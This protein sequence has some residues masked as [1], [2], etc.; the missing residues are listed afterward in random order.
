MKKNLPISF[1]I[2]SLFFTGCSINFSSVQSM[3]EDHSLAGRTFSYETL[4]LNIKRNSFDPG[5]KKINTNIY[6]SN[7][8][9]DLFSK[10]YLISQDGRSNLGLT[11]KSKS[12]RHK[13]TG[14]D[15]IFIFTLGLF[16]T[17]ESSESIV[18]FEL[19]DRKNQKVIRTW[20]YDASNTAISSWLT[21][22]FSLLLSPFSNSVSTAAIGED[23]AE[24]QPL[25]LL[26]EKFLQDFEYSLHDEKFRREVQ[27]LATID[28]STYY[29]AYPVDPAGNLPQRL[30][31]LLGNTLQDFF[32]KNKFPTEAAAT[33]EYNLDQE[34]DLDIID[35]FKEYDRQDLIIIPFLKEHTGNIYTGHLVMVDSRNKEVVFDQDFKIFATNAEQLAYRLYSTF[36]QILFAKDVV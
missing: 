13:Y 33:I 29:I 34:N 17:V 15:L 10:T 9:F 22:P 1:I 4:P 28:H 21:I 6:N 26:I 14:M 7:L 23:T 2:A 20:R 12:T 19:K 35:H 24:Q 16:P 31:T 5:F 30:K 36:V 25:K 3:Y 8:L 27:S 32:S 18:Q 11:F